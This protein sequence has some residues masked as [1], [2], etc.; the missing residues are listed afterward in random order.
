MI[1]IGGV[2]RVRLWLNPAVSFK[3]SD[4]VWRKHSYWTNKL[5]TQKNDLVSEPA[6]GFSLPLARLNCRFKSLLVSTVGKYLDL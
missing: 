6:V 4:R 2:L 3:V 1:S 5:R